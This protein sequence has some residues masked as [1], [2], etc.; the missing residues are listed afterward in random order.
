MLKMVSDCCPCQAA[1]EITEL[2]DW[3][4]ALPSDLDCVFVTIN[5]A[6][7]WTCLFILN[8]F[9]VWDISRFGVTK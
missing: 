5:D 2:Q 3:L 6:K 9:H 8:S 4:F 1:L 7:H